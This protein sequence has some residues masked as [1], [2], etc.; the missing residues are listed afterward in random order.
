MLGFVLI[1]LKNTGM[2]IYKLS[3]FTKGWIVGNFSPSLFISEEFEV[4][5]KKYK[6]GD[7]EKLH[8]HKKA[9]EITIIC[10]GKVKMNNQQFSE[11]DVIVIQPNQ[12]TDF[13]VIEDA[14]T[15]VIKTPSLTNDKFLI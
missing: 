5:V 1:L 12:A 15:T 6:S 13:F 4:A 3:E 8:F 9:L 7:Y 11:G 10:S 14:I 2:E